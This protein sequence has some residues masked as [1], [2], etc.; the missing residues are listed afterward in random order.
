M[1]TKRAWLALLLTVWMSLACS[2]VRELDAPASRPSD[3]TARRTENADALAYDVTIDIGAP[4]GVVWAV[5]TDASS[6]TTWN[7]TIVSLEGAIAKDGNIALVAKTDPDRTFELAVTT[8]DPPSTMVWEDGMP[9]GLFAGVRTFALSPVDEQTTRFSMQEVFS[10]GMLSM[11]A[12]ELPDF[13]P[14]FEAFAKDLKAQAEKIAAATPTRAD[15]TAGAPTATSDDAAP[16][17]AATEPAATEAT[18]S[19]P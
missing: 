3:G 17:A 10:G 11:I 5:L 13:R 16:E 1:T 4:I 8:F 18:P 6:Y 7:S 9:L 15:G 12:G 19:T 2:T 14:S